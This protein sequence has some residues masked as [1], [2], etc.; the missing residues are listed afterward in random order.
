MRF[1][2]L[3]AIMASQPP[4]FR[5][6]HSLDGLLHKVSALSHRI[7]KQR[8]RSRIHHVLRIMKDDG[9]EQLP[10][11]PFIVAQGLMQAI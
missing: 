9:G 7:I 1:G 11:S 3:F 6:G 4:T 10:T 8:E 2:E 5:L